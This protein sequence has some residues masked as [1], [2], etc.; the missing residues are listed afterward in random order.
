M[1]LKIPS[2]GSSRSGFTLPEILIAMT[3]FLL[4][5]AGIIAANLF[6]LRMFQVN[7]TKLTATQ[8]SR[9]TFGKMTDEI[10]ACSSMDILNSDT[11]GNLTGLLD[12]DVQQGNGIQIFPTTN[13]DT[14]IMYF[15]NLSDATFRQRIGKPSGTNTVSLA[16][17]VTNTIA[18]SAQDFSGNVLTHNLN[19]RVIHVTLDFYK[20]ER[21]MLDSDFYKLETSVTRR[22]LQ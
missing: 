11:N 13:T 14:F 16:D 8:W 20:P 7:N 1:K 12:G 17:S 5:V 3:I 2:S 10:H 4:V 6:G 15:V 9:D 22:A 19:N 18:F 21:F